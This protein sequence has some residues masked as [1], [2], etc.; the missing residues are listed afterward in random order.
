MIKYGPLL[1]PI[2]NICLNLTDACNLACRYCFVQQKPNYI[3]LDIAKRT[4]HWLHENNE[5][6]QKEYD[7]VNVPAIVFFGGEPTLLWD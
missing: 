7:D 2:T 1:K 5:I 6:V 3:T 4:L